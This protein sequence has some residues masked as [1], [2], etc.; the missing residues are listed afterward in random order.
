MAAPKRT[1]FERERDRRII[2]ELYLLKISQ[3]EMPYELK[4]KTGAYYLLSQP[5]IN[6]ELKKIK[7]MWK[8][9]GLIDF[10]FAK[11]KELARIDALEYEHWQAWNKSINPNGNPKYL[12]GVLKCIDSRCKLFGFYDQKSNVEKDHPNNSK[13]SDLS[14]EEVR[15]RLVKIFSNNIQ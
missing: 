2:S 7:K 5:M 1:K 13:Y 10:N 14:I 12:D 6:Y 8:T 3:L 15:E 4:F 11:N 9:E